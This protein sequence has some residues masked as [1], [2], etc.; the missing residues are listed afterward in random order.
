MIYSNNFYATL[1]DY[2][3]TII[4]NM[5]TDEKLDKIEILEYLPELRHRYFDYY[6]KRWEI[7]DVFRIKTKKSINLFC[8]SNNL[9][10]AQKSYKSLKKEFN[11]KFG[12][13]M[14]WEKVP[15]MELEDLK[16]GIESLFKR[17]GGLNED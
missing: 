9:T 11:C 1:T 7:S 13:K 2:S 3:K 6:T 5:D 15:E 16:V 12:K 14:T 10:I 17:I 4:K 8:Y